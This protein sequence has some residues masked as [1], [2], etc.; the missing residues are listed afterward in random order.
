[1]LVDF[2]DQ[3]SAYMNILQPQSDVLRIWEIEV[4]KIYFFL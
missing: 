3:P 1:M 4:K 2:T